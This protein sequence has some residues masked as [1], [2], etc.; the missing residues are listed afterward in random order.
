MS[1]LAFGKK[2]NECTIAWPSCKDE[3]ICKKNHRGGSRGRSRVDDL[4]TG[5]LSPVR[6]A[7]TH[8][9][10]KC[11]AQGLERDGLR[12]HDAPEGLVQLWAA[13]RVRAR[14]LRGS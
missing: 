11:E 13:G 2:G 12:A 9:A 14:P 5:M 6:H 8:P 4:I 1:S 3:K 10:K 7:H